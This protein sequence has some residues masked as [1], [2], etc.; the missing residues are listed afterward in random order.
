MRETLRSIPLI[1]VSVIL[2]VLLFAVFGLIL[3]AVGTKEET[4]IQTADGIAYLE[5]LEKKDPSAIRQVRQEIYQR[6]I[7][8]QRQVLINQLTSGDKDPFTMF[9]DYVMMGDSRQALCG[10]GGRSG[11]DRGYQGSARRSS[12]I[13]WHP[14]QPDRLLP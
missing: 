4:N 12:R 10:Y 2:A 13:R 9:R 14:L 5:S 11:S 3:D 1:I 8:A 7:N 6:E